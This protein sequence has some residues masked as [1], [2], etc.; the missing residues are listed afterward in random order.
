LTVESCSPILA[1]VKVIS[2]TEL[3]M[4]EHN[5]GLQRID[6]LVERDVRMLGVAGISFS[7][8]VRNMVTVINADPPLATKV[9][10]MA[11]VT[12]DDA[13]VGQGEPEPPADW[14]RRRAKKGEVNPSKFYKPFVLKLLLG[15]PGHGLRAKKAL[16]LLEP[17]LRPDLKPADYASLPKSGAPR[18]PNKVQWARLRLVEDGLLE[19]VEEAGRGV[20]KLTPAGV[21]AAQKLK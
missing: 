5:M 8:V 16:K 15:A 1:E 9:R 20:W 2:L 4:V 19:P 6:N 11:F 17:I 7:D 10:E 3:T 12:K 14:D 13:P 18:W 21:K